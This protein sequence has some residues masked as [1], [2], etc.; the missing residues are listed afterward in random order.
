MRITVLIVDDHSMVADGLK[1]LLEHEDDI[2][3]V[4]IANT[5]ADALARVFEL[6]PKVV[7]MDYRLPDGDGITTATRIFKMLPETQVVI[8]TGSGDEDTVS[9]ALHAG[10]I[11]YLEKTMALDRIGPAVRQAARGELV[12]SASDLAR[13]MRMPSPAGRRTEELTER[14]IE[15]LELLAVGLANREIADRLYL[16]VHTVR[17]HIRALL[18][19]LGA[20]N[21]LE[22][23]ALARRQH[24][25]D[26]EPIHRP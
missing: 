13:A 22:A 16:S 7:L 4:G 26:R 25:I 2:D 5:A 21:R 6:R 20:H 12:V 1:R 9:E 24:L 18:S 11:G 3:V 17:S 8:V 23:V 15:V 19:K 14:E 10:C